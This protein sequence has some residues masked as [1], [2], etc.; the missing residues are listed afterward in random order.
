MFSTTV[1]GKL[2]T[3]A[4]IFDPPLFS[5]DTIFKETR[6]RFSCLCCSKPDSFF[7]LCLHDV[8]ILAA[9]FQK[10]YLHVYKF[11]YNFIQ[12]E[13][14]NNRLKKESIKNVGLNFCSSMFQL[15]TRH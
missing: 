7:G 3:I 1:P 4:T 13:V 12:H 11:V 10:L 8:H 14:V 6:L 9:T 2:T 15:I 5:L